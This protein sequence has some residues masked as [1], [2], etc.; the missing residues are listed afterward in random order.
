MS[1][2]TEIKYSIPQ[3]LLEK[4]YLVLFNRQKTVKGG[5][6]IHNETDYEVTHCIAEL[7]KID[8]GLKNN[9]IIGEHKHIDTRT[10]AD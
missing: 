2:E 3:S 4:I 1:K 8:K 5:M 10:M 9:L 6:L 7:D